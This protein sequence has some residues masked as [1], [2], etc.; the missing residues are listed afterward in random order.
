MHEL[1]GKNEKSWCSVP[2]GTS[3]CACDA[4]APE[5]EAGSLQQKAQNK[6][7]NPELPHGA[8]PW[9]RDRASFLT[10]PVAS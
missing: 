10:E 9:S 1:E 3:P 7:S 2:L 8:L 6:E 5:A 4:A